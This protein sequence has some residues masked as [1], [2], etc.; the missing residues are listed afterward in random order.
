M[1]NINKRR[2]ISDEREKQ[3]RRVKN[4]IR[5]LGEAK[6]EKEEMADK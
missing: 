1:T 6:K 5:S 3:L 4:M 2:T